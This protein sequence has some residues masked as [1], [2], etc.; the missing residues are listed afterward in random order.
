MKG[1]V[2]HVSEVKTSKLGA[3]LLTLMVIF[4][5]SIS[6]NFLN[7]ISYII[8]K[9]LNPS[10]CV[11]QLA[12]QSKEDLIE[13]PCQGI[14]GVKRF[15]ESQ[16][17]VYPYKFNSTDIQYELDTKYKQTITDLDSLFVLNKDLKYQG[18]ML[19][20]QRGDLIDQDPGLSPIQ[21][22]LTKQEIQDITQQRDSEYQKIKP[23]LNSLKQEYKEA[24]NKVNFYKFFYFL[25]E[26]FLQLIFVL[27]FFVLGLKKYFQLKKQNSPF[28]V[29]ATAVVAAASILLLQV[30]L[31]FLFK[32]LPWGFLAKI[33]TWF[34][35]FQFLKYILYYSIVVA[36]IA[37]F[38]GVVYYIQKSNYASDKVTKRRLLKNQCP[39]CETKI[40]D[41]YNNCRGCGLEL[42]KTCP[43]CKQNTSKFFKFCSNCGHNL[44]KK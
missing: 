29:I 16:K 20:S 12:T 26:L 7:D 13:G 25:A 31:G 18:E 21:I 40:K 5:F 38:G 11:L 39:R 6:Q 19:E 10:V 23:K 14:K 15:W 43:G 2:E 37:L 33:W 1:L 35:N 32:A 8:K 36:T 4:I 22:K 42:K 27:P 24:Y 9:P 28:T 3:I 34:Q 41:S 30:V 17:R 44:T